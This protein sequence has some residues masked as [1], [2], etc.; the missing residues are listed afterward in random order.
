M[1]TT[2][3]EVLCFDKVLG[4]HIVRKASIKGP[5]WKDANTLLAETSTSE[6]FTCHCWLANG[7]LLFGTSCGRVLKVE[8]KLLSSTAEMLQKVPNSSPQSWTML[9]MDPTSCPTASARD[10]CKFD[11]CTRSLHFS[12]PIDYLSAIHQSLAQCGEYHSEWQ[13]VWGADAVPTKGRP[14]SAWGINPPL[15]V[16]QL[17]STAQLTATNHSI[18]NLHLTAQHL[19]VISAPVKGATAAD[20][21]AAATWLDASQLQLV[22][23]CAL[24]AGT[25]HAWSAPCSDQ[26]TI[27]CHDG[28]V[29]IVSTLPQV[30][31]A[32]ASTLA[33]CAVQ[34]PCCCTALLL[35]SA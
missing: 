18:L 14:G 35:V 10:L 11:V 3:A 22:A 5:A 21:K 30:S 17:L 27:T 8:G 15:T 6:T 13:S 4:S 9:H 26:M 19:L 25:C 32:P 33:A 23:E 24:P 12:T 1:G 28:D 34:F 16:Q 31:T 7:S 2:A 29:Y 20:G